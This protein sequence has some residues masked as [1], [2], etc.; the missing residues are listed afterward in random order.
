MWTTE[1]EFSWLSD[2]IPERLKVKCKPGQQIETWLCATATEFT[3]VFPARKDLGEKKLVDVSP[4]PLR[5][6][7]DSRSQFLRDCTAGTLTM[8]QERT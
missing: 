4:S 3:T 1:S 5:L 2:R 6:P 8:E 7:Y